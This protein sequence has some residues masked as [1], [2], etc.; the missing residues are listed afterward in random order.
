[1]G[2]QEEH[3][4]IFYQSNILCIGLIYK[5]AVSLSLLSRALSSVTKYLFYMHKVPGSASGTYRYVEP[6]WERFL[7][8][9]L[10]SHAWPQYTT[11]LGCLSGSIPHG[12]ILEP[13]YSFQLMFPLKTS[14]I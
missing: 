7:P 1:M 5:Q 12:Q 6:G 9:A 10:E 11:V 8:C 2:T 14:R 4:H 13:T 3:M